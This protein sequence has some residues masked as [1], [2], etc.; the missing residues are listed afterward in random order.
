MTRYLV[1][2]RGGPVALVGSIEL[3]CEIV[4]T[5]P[6]GCYAVDEI[7]VDPLVS[8]PEVQARRRSTRH[9]D[10]RIKGGPRV[11][12]RPTFP[13]TESPDKPIHDA[14]DSVRSESA[15][16]PVSETPIKSPPRSP[17]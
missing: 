5:Q 17:I 15:Y 12:S 6:P 13:P 3:A 4:C 2:E 10:G 14:A 7:Q 8:A 11:R 16:W 1:R 9:P